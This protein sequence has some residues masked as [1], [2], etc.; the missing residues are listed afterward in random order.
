MK[1]GEMLNNNE[2]IIR[3]SENDNVLVTEYYNEISCRYEFNFYHLN[4]MKHWYTK[5]F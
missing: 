4:T 1:T 3:I 5:A 2:K